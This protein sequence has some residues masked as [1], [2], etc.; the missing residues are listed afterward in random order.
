M[1]RHIFAFLMAVMTALAPAQ[2]APARPSSPSTYVLVHGAWGTVHAYDGAEA[3]L[4]A[5]GHKVYVVAL[6]GLGTRVSE[7]SP[8]ITLSDHIADVVKIIDEN[9]LTNIILIG[10]SYGGMVITGV[11][12]KRAAHIRTLVYLDAFLPRD[13]EALWDIVTEPERK[14][15]IDAQRDMPGLIRPFVGAPDQ[16]QRQPLLTLL[17]PVHVSGDEHLIKN[18]SYVFADHGAPATFRKFYD[19]VTADPTWRTAVLNSGHMLMFDQPDALNA[20]L[21]AE[22]NR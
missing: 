18:H 3:A 1:F 19:R 14:H 5:Q 2:A 7:R 15:F 21:L 9:H 6:K 16:S 4:R 13:G 22:A 11:A 17:E 10:H 20:F 12:A 8:A